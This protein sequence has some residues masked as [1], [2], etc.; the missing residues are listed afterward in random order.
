MTV[1]RSGCSLKCFSKPP[2]FLC[3][4]SVSSSRFKYWTTAQILIY[5]HGGYSITA[6]TKLLSWSTAIGQFFLTFIYLG[7]EVCWVNMCLFSTTPLN[8]FLQLHS[9]TT[10]FY[11]ISSEL[12][13]WRG[14]STQCLI[15]LCL[16]GC[17]WNR[18]EPA[19]RLKLG[20]ICCK[21]ASHP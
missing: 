4:M 18:G 10:V 11:W 12:L 8:I 1:D 16:T 15:K 20:T 3:V 5:V 6:L 14:L 17:C 21:P 13:D 9:S 19:N 7:Y 2:L